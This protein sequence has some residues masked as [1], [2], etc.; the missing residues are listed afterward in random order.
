MASGKAEAKVEIEY[1][2]RWRIEPEFP[3]RQANGS[4]LIQVSVK[5]GPPQPAPILIVQITTLPTWVPLWR[6]NRIIAVWQFS[7][8]I[9]YSAIIEAVL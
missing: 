5:S 6:D 7:K 2:T 9:F 8:A 3:A 1:E 4:V